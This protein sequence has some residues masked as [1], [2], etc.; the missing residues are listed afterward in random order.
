M[1]EFNDYLYMNFTRKN[2]SFCLV[3]FGDDLLTR[4]LP[5]QAKVSNI[6]I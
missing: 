6:L 1:L 3:T 4:I 5:S 2:L